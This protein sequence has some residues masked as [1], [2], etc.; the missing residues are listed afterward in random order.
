M[1]RI[2]FAIPFLFLLQLPQLISAQTIKVKQDKTV[3]KCY[4][5]ERINELR[6]LNPNSE[7]DQHFENWMQQKIAEKKLFRATGTSTIIIPIIFHIISQGEAIGSSG[8][9]ANPA[10]SYINQQLLQLNKDYA[11]L[12]N[13]IYAV[14][15][16]T[17]IQFVLAKTDTTGSNLAEP[18]IDRINSIT[19]GFTDYNSSAW[20]P[21]YIDANVK[22]ATI[23]N[24]EK[25]YNVWVI[26]N[27]SIGAVNSTLLGYSTFP[28]SSGLNG[29]SNGETA[30]TAGVVIKT[31][32]LGSIF[33]P[34]N[35]GQG[36]GLGKTLTHETGHFLGLRHIW[37]DATCGDDF[38][39]DTPVHTTSN[40]GVPIH[41][42]PNSCGTAD[43]MFENYMDYSDDIV[44][45]TF[46]N[47]QVSRMQ[48][49]MANSPR[50]IN[51][52]TSTVGAVAG[53]GSNK[54]AFENCTGVLTITEA[55]S[56]GSYP[57][58]R[59]LHLILNAE[60]IAT[61]AATVSIAASG[62]AISNLQY[63]ILTPTVTFAAGDNYKDII[64][65][66]IDNAAVDGNRN[67]DL[68][69]T[70]NGSGVTA[71]SNA[72]TLNITVVDDD[73]VKVGLNS[74]T[75]YNENFGTTGGQLP[76]NWT[77]GSFISTAGKNIFNVG[78]NGGA[79]ITGQALY[80]T[81][82]TS[83]K[84]L[85][86][87]ST[88]ASDAVAI[89]PI[90]STIGYKNASLSFNYKCNGESSG[91]SSS[92]NDY[93][94]IMYTTDNTN[95]YTLADANGNNYVYQGVTTATN[96]GSI[97]LPAALQNTNFNLGFRWINNNSIGNNPPFLIDDIFIK[98][99]PEA[100][101]STIGTSFGFDIQANSSSNIFRD[102]STN[103]V[104]A[105]INN[106]SAN[107]AGITAKITQQGSGTEAIA[108]TGGAF[109]RTQKVY[110]VSPATANTTA[111][112]QATFY[113]TENELAVWG[114][115]KLNLKF[116]KV[117]DSTNLN[118]T[119]TQS[120]SQIITPTVSENSSAGYI[121]YTGNFTGFS[122]FM[123]VEQAT[124]LPV[125][126]INFEVLGQSNALL[127][128]WLTAIE[129]NSKG[130]M[131]QRGTDGINFKD[132]SY[133][134]SRGNSNQ[135][136][137]YSF[138]DSYVQPGKVY[139]YRLR[140]I[141]NNDTYSFSPTK[142]GSLAGHSGIEITVSP[143]PAKNHI[144][145]FIRGTNN[146]ATMVL[147]NAGAQ[148]LKQLKEVNAYDGVYTLQLPNLPKGIYN[149]LIILPEGS[150]NKKIIIE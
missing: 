21:S 147:L 19:K 46:T 8:N 50:R 82:N 107:L 67:I 53:T 49:V 6:K 56:T 27:I 123:L 33:S 31:A 32:T 105:N 44:L 134:E 39:T 129:I 69:Y 97:L 143:N 111:T 133:F 76:T 62:T 29:L 70:I 131:L 114:S 98:G 7:S 148:K 121:A 93:G 140:Q 64:V 132:L 137:A 55:G 54:I 144:N 2:I 18:G 106:T 30:T 37:G 139:F 136:A 40:Y 110:R 124:V 126:L 58:Y 63:K 17:G 52:A 145:I 99:T 101:D 25:Y 24:A 84:L 104:V 146:K 22:P 116:L 117:K 83:T 118:S 14:A 48:T 16:N 115:N 51:L 26:P 71:G 113:F 91:T 127:I 36:F 79:G 149:L 77:T 41:P 86:Y 150:F 96:S 5:T 90:I 42:K 10:A 12:S 20:S 128:K 34:F 1:K 3:V 112:Y 95:Y 80:V 57:R 119:L 81:N 11:N 73:N 13:S 4:T 47:N 15:A 75:I 45:N 23:F 125:S 74:A 142:N 68:S 88:S 102:D 78:S 89:T 35:C 109:N 66:L 65:R 100:P 138:T 60:N 108:T 120:N 103:N 72:Q 87:D 59:D 130:F 61:G 92:P 135:G 85:N 38:C 122:Q 28:A 9:V 43:E 94:E 141:S